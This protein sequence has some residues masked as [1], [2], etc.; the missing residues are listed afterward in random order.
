M[1]YLPEASI[2]DEW[3]SKTAASIIF[4]QEAEKFI[5]LSKDELKIALLNQAIEKIKTGELVFQEYTTLDEYLL[6]ELKETLL[7]KIRSTGHLPGENVFGYIRRTGVTNEEIAQALTQLVREGK[8]EFYIRKNQFLHLKL[9]FVAREEGD[10]IQEKPKCSN[11]DDTGLL[12]KG[13]GYCKCPQGKK[14]AEEAMVAG[15]HGL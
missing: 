5:R 7:Q 11:C 2:S 6:R 12:H 4:F 1:D 15:E 9:S 8:L 3:M 13:H 14:M 10:K